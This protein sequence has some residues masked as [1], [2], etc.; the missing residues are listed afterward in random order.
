[1]GFRRT[2]MRRALD[3]VTARHPGEVLTAMPVQAILR[4]PRPRRS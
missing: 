4:R 2:A 3:A 1:M